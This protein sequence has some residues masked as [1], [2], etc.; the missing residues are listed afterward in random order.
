MDAE[1]LKL[2]ADPPH[3]PTTAK[4]TLRA[5][6]WGARWVALAVI[7]GAALAAWQGPG[8]LLGPT[9]AVDRVS[10]ATLIATVVATGNVETPHRVQIGAQITG[11]V[12]EVNVTEGQRVTQGQI[13][14]SLESHELINAEVL[15]QGALEQAQ[16]HM[17]QLAELT[18]PTARDMLKQAQST[19]LN[20]QQTFDRAAVLAR[21][22]YETR[23][24]LDQSQKDL[25][26]ARSQVRAAALSV[27]TNAPGG[28]DYVT[29]ETQLTQA[30]ASLDTATARLGYATITA[31][32]DGVLITRSVENGAVVQPG[33]AL[34]GLAPDGETQLVLAIDE[35]NLGRLKLGQPAIASADAYAGQ[36]FAAVVSYINP[37]VDISR[38]SVEVKL[39]V[40]SPPAYL[41]QDMTVSV[42][43]QVAQATDALVL[44]TDAVRDALTPAPWALV[45]RSGRAQRQTVQLGVQ[46]T[47]K[48]Q[49]LAG[50]AEGDSVVPAASS[51]TAGQRVR[52]VA[53]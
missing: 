12:A 35:R 1:P 50:L 23:V 31:P 11:T 26:I 15:A 39:T 5:R 20:A 40:A 24:V 38:A 42:D 28:S 45:V 27:V 33:T 41:I 51:V 25:D 18:L 8:L 4:R 17:R 53:K 16:A 6:L 37:G 10:R 13:L 3:P 22:G 47:V 30:K 21:Q 7:G 29:G 44:P 32:R 43:I 2:T 34:L 48:T 49:I 19:L 46:G 36:T 9:V 52:S 14:V